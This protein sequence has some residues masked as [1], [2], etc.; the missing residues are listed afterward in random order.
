MRKIRWGILST[1]HIAQTQVI[2]AIIRSSN[3]EVIGIASRGEEQAK[4]LAS[5][6]SIPKHYDS[7]ENLL[8]D[9]EIEAV[10]IPLPN[11]L[12]KEWVIEAAKHGKHVLCEKP[13][14]LSSEEAKEM[15]QFCREQNVKF[16]EAF[17]Y[18]FHPQH[19]RVDEI[20][21]SGE[22]GEIKLMRASFSFYL[23]SREEN[24]RMNKKMGGG[25]IYDVGCYGIHSIR[26]LLKT[27]PVEV[28]AYANLDSTS[29]VDLSAVISM[30]LANGVKAVVDCSMDMA[31]R[32]EYEMVGTK[33][34]LTVPRAFRPDINEGEGLIIVHSEQGFRIEKI[35][36]DQYK[37]QMEYFSQ[38]IMED[39][40]PY[41][42]AENTIVNMQV[43]EVCYQ[44]IEDKKEILLD[45]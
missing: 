24:I 34:R 29:G 19:R 20:L 12:H 2:P 3:A 33:G 21:A 8:R 10:Y 35:H 39:F 30:K 22:L 43:I 1:A 37:N 25:S 17:M 7:Y 32:H 41:D 40:F 13:A 4:E 16:M 45:F 36:G 6:F 28:R 14:S 18:Q 38:A 15:V 5:A 26:S 42:Q 11:H 23:E 44:S 27:E 9:Q 31:F